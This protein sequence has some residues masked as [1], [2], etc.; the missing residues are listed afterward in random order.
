MTR[1]IEQYKRAC[2]SLAGGV[3]SS[4]RVNQALGHAMLFDR[5]D[6]C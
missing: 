4:T 2:N 1:V 3:S 5:A 6:G